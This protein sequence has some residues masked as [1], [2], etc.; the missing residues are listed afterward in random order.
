MGEDIGDCPYEAGDA[1]P[2][3][4]N[5]IFNGRTPKY[6]LATVL[7]VEACP[8]ASAGTMNGAFLMTQDNILPCTWRWEDAETRAV[9]EF[10]DNGTDFVLHSLFGL[11]REFFWGISPDLCRDKY[12]NGFTTC[13]PFNGGRFG[14]LILTWGCSIRP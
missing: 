14:N 2:H 11:K 4:H 9:L 10:L 1:C 12:P 5:V 3:C 8:D 7:G 6:V 13:G